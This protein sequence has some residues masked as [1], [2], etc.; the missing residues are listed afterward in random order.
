MR[1]G[2]ET[3]RADDSKGGE[4]SLAAQGR[5]AHQPNRNQRV[6]HQA[7]ESRRQK[8]AAKIDRRRDRK[9]AF[10]DDKRPI[11]GGEP[12]SRQAPRR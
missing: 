8:P 2:G 7:D 5:A 12:A 3:E 11:I 9:R 10:M 6:D 1:D 4:R